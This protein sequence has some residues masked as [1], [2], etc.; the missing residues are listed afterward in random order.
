MFFFKV[1]HSTG[2]VS[3][4]VGQIDMKRK[5]CASVGYWVNSVTLTFDLY[6]D[7]DLWFSIVKFQNSCTSGFVIW[8]MW[9][10][11]KA[12][13]LE[14]VLT[15]WTTPHDLDLAVSRSMFEIA[16]FEEW[17]GWLTWNERNVSPD[18][19]DSGWGDFRRRRAIGIS[20]YLSMLEYKI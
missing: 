11:K 8:L 13:L 15:V 6:H 7:L 2:H 19:P 10:R 1:K 17:E 9:N 4:M 12:N 18:V 5:W 16:L 20:S 3:G 14:T